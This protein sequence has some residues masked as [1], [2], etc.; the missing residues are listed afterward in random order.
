MKLQRLKSRTTA[1]ASSRKLPTLAQMHDE[2]RMRGRALMERNQRLLQRNGLCV[3][4]TKL[5]D[6]Q[7]RKLG[8]G[9]AVDEWDH[10]IPLW[11]GGVDDESN[12]QGLCH[13]HHDE[14][15]ERERIEREQYGKSLTIA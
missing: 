11:K 6:A 5:G 7:A 9:V 15:S 2:K 1:F 14:K 8:Y 4:C 3:E 12:L 13:K 10:T